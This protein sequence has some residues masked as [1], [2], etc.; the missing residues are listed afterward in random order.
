M[1]LRKEVY[2]FLFITLAL[3]ALFSHDLRTA[4]TGPRT[5][6]V[7]VADGGE[8][9]PPPLPPSPTHD[10]AQLFVAD[11]GEPPPPPLPPK[12]PSRALAG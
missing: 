5:P 8:P 2:L 10:G 9:P 4:T 6:V 7:S 3:I 1:R 12:P 11:G